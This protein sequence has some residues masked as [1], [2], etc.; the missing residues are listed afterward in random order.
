MKNTFLTQSVMERQFLTKKFN[1]AKRRPSTQKK[2]LE[3]VK[4]KETLQSE[5][6][7][8]YYLCKG[9]FLYVVLYPERYYT[10]TKQNKSLN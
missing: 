5:N 10:S 8:E 4:I 2:P 7:T 9:M 3:Y 6:R 1:V